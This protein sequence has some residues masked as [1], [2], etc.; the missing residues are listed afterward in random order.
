MWSIFG[1][2]YKNLIDYCDPYFET[3]EV[4]FCLFVEYCKAVWI[5][6][7]QVLGYFCK[8]FVCKRTLNVVRSKVYN[9]SRHRI[10]Y[11]SVQFLSE[12]N[13]GG[14]LRCKRRRKSLKIF[15]RTYDEYYNKNEHINWCVWTWRWGIIMYFLQSI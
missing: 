14:F 11:V 1:Y 9:N 5:S 10:F 13:Q 4:F 6:L 2:C 15:W 8:N 7:S 3:M 12:K